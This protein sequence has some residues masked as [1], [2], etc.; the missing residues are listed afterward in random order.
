MEGGGWLWLLVAVGLIALAA[1]I[2]SGT[3]MWRHRR[4]DPRA[5]AETAAATR[6]NYREG[7]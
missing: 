5:K 4:K 7:G 2:A 6:R 1:G 3:Q